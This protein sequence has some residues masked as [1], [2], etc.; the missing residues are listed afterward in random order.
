MDL[1]I[2]GIVGAIIANCM[3]NIKKSKSKIIFLLSICL[4]SVVAES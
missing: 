4:A 3:K 2:N 1:I